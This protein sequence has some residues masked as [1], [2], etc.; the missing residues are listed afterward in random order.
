MKWFCEVTFKLSVTENG[1]TTEKDL[2]LKI[3]Y[4]ISH[5]DELSLDR[6]KNMYIF[7]QQLLFHPTFIL[8]P[9]KRNGFRMWEDP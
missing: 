2:T 9:N 5:D 3:I 8:D 7:L 1:L 4:L 6:Q